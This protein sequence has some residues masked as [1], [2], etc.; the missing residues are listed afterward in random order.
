LLFQEHHSLILPTTVLPSATSPEIL[1]QSFAAE[2]PFVMIAKA[3]PTSSRPPK[4][5]E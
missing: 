4:V 5:A 2:A 1:Y 3:D